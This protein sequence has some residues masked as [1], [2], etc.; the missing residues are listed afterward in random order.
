[1]EGVKN[2]V[3]TLLITQSH[4]I[5]SM[6]KGDDNFAKEGRDIIIEG[7]EWVKLQ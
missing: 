5:T 6:L 1:M 4:L 2:I 7:G 3:F